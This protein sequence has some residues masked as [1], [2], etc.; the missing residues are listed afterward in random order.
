[1]SSRNSG[2]STVKKKPV[3][4]LR[5]DS[6]GPPP[7]KKQKTKVLSSFPKPPFNLYASQLSQSQSA[8]D[9]KGKGKEKDWSQQ[10]SSI[11]DDQLWVDKYGPTSEEDLAVH[12]KKVQDVRQ[13]L[14]EAFQGGLNGKLKKY[15][16]ILAL[17][18]PAGTGKT[19]AIRVL[20]RELDFDILEWRNAMDERFS[21]E[22]DYGEYE[23]LSEKFQS[24]LARAARCSSLFS[25]PA[26]S[27]TLSQLS[28]ASSSTAPATST[29]QARRQI[30]LLEDLPNILHAG[31]RDAFHAALEAFINSAE[32]GVAPIVLIISDAGVRGESGD[33][34]VGGGASAWRTRREAVD[35]RSVLPQTMLGSPFVT[36]IGFN[37]VAPTYLRK[38]LQNLLRTHFS[39]NVGTPPS[40][41][42]VDLVVESSN[43]DIRSAVMALQFACV[44]NADEGYK[45]GS[46][47][48]PKSAIPRA[49]LEVVTRREHSMAL[50]HLLG[51]LLYNKRKRDPPAPSASAKDIQRNRDFDSQLHDPSPLPPHLQ[52]HHRRT[53]RVDVEILYADT[54]VDASLLSLY[55]HQNYSQYCETMEQ[56]DALADWLSWI[57]ASGGEAWYQTNP[58][59]FHLLALSTLHSLPSPVVRR[60][61][62]PYKP[63]FFDALR[64]SRAAEGAVGDVLEWVL[65]SE[66]GRAGGWT[67][68]DVALRLGGVLKARARS[69][70]YVPPVHKLFSWLEW[71][72][73]VGNLSQLAEDGDGDTPDPELLEHSGWDNGREK[74]VE[75]RGGWLED[76]DIEDFDS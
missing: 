42:V 19:A 34:D 12:K 24:F 3:S 18:G 70:M 29:S 22:D 68:E 27:A 26:S 25:T 60:A 65:H 51:K 45:R 44:S 47:K 53:S 72:K 61:Q 6:P 56:C 38:A 37:P 67:R 35:V 9:V 63:A 50:F 71:S 23:G 36:Q 66:E 75:V 4:T 21:T 48:A 2:K 69:G 40:K 10:S 13:W 28:S 73:G 31:T 76:D 11:E 5:L 55:I 32:P 41:E 39:R 54:P 62:K 8:K 74:E 52:E 30:I 57:D 1:M 49:L 7:A 59:H 33:A 64:R 46:Q 15:R 14:L 20:A 58:Y 16:R 17:T 43:G